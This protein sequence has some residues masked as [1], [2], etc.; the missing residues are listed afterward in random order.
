MHSDLTKAKELLDSGEFQKAA[1][2][3]RNF[4]ESNGKHPEAYYIRGI[5]H[6]KLQ[7]F[8]SSLSDF[9]ALVIIAPHVADSYAERGVTHF[10]LKNFESCLKDMNKA[11]ELEPKNAYRY[12]SRA[13]IKGYTGDIEGAIADYK[14]AIQL[15]PDDEIAHNNLGLM[16]E[17]LGYRKQS[18]A[19]FK[20]SNEILKDKYGIEVN[21][22]VRIEQSEIK[23]VDAKKELKAPVQHQPS[24]S[25]LMLS[26]FNNKKARKDFFRFW[27]QK[28]SGNK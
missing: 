28:L 7:D 2:A 16:Q 13:Y 11:I 26:V 8:Q 24:L 20:R 27:K 5:A 18:H 3:V 22:E 14:L 23:N 1:N 17:K 12:S 25:E 15:D 21:E 6:R 19:S 10:H 9:D 4:I